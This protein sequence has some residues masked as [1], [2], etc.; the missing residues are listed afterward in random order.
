MGP[1]R[2]SVPVF[3]GGAV[4]G[5]PSLDDE[6]MGAAEVPSYLAPMCPQPLADG[7]EELVE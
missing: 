4:T 6:G 2:T 5:R 1:R 3:A 7:L